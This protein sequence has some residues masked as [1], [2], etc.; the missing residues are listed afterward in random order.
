[1]KST[2]NVARRTVPRLS[3]TRSPVLRTPSLLRRCLSSLEP[4][5]TSTDTAASQGRGTPMWMKARQIYDGEVGRGID[6]APLNISV[7][8]EIEGFTCLSITPVPELETV[9][10]LN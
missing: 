8:D 6:R 9:Q 5:L 4:S 3:Q 1:M 10:V 2:A 7:G